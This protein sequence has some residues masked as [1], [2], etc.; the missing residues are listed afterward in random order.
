[1]YRGPGWKFWKPSCVVLLLA[2]FAA[3]H[4]GNAQGFVN[5]VQSRARVFPE[6]N[7]GVTA[8]KRDSSRRYYVLATPPNVIWIFSPEGK[9]IGQIPRA[10]A[11]NAKIQY[12]V[13]F[14][15]DSEGFL[16]VADRAA[17]AV[18]IFSPDGSLLK[19]ISVPA[20]T[21]V[22]ALPENQFAVSTLRSK[23][24]VEIYTDQGDLV[25]SFGDPVE[26]GADPSKQLQNLGRVFGDGNADIYF[27]FTDLP[28]PTVRKY[29]RFGYA[30]TNVTL[31][32]NLYAPSVTPAPN[33][34]VQFGINFSETSFSDSYN[35]WA[36]IGN[37]GDVFF[38][39]GLSPGLG[40]HVGE[41]PATA[42]SATASILS[43]GQAA[44]PG[45]GGPGGTAGG[46]MVSAQGTFQADSLQFHLGGKPKRA[47]T[48]DD[49]Q[50]SQVP[51]GTS[52]AMLFTAPG[53]SSSDPFGSFNS[54]DSPDGLLSFSQPAGQGANAGTSGRGI[55]GGMGGFG[56]AGM[57]GGMG[58][59]QGLFSGI[60]GFGQVG[61]A[62]FGGGQ[63]GSFGKN[64][65]AFSAPS[66][67]TGAAGPRSFQRGPGDFHF[68]GGHGRYGEGL[69]NLTGTVK[70]NLDHLPSSSGDKAVITAVAVDRVSQDIWAAIGRVLVHFDRNGDYL[71]DYYMATPDGAPLR[72]SAIIVEPDRLIVA[73]ESR[74]IYEFPRSDASVSHS[75][76]TGSLGI[77]RPAQQS[78]SQ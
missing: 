54:S 51:S 38:G 44:G 69:Y 76:V 37:K 62:S 17:N 13:D 9:R 56:G 22:V 27:A 40:A 42:Q 2:G 39:G 65:E 53:S 33:D 15:L 52:D 67:A 32:A 34:R 64:V 73:S 57:F 36:A 20:P 47:G 19:S 61:G 25:R 30:A 14:D 55:M 12:A 6:I 21:G 49:S 50:N 68:G 29:D 48:A 74:G 71:G 58:L 70:V 45:G 46:G 26:A 18:E 4:R 24:L 59:G 41:G 7:S 16:L 28:D 31:A 3:P 66:S 10:G 63:G 78:T 11:E 5:A 60:G 75:V 72:A 43:T 1:M 77:Q 35:T 23:R 8:M